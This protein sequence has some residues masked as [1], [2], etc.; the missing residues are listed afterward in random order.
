MGH[1]LSALELQRG[2]SSNITLGSSRSV[3]SDNLW[4]VVDTTLSLMGRSDLQSAVNTRDLTDL[5]QMFSH[6]SQHD[7]VQDS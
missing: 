1:F 5:L 7:V 4:S 3:M 2:A 6:S